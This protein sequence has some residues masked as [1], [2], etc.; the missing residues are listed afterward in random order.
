MDYQKTL[1]FLY[2]SLPQ[3]QRIGGAAYKAGLQTTEL[4]DQALGSPHQAYKT[5]H[6]AGTN[7]KGSTSQMIYEALRADGHRVGLY[8][9]PH[10]VDFRERIVVDNQMITHAGVVSFVAENRELIDRLCPSFFELTV[11]MALWWFREQKVDWAVVE[12]G[13]GG[14]LDSTN[15]ITPELSVITNISKDHTQFLGTT[16]QAI[17]AE[18]AGIIKPLVPV[19]VGEDSGDEVAAV[20]RR[21]AAEN[22]SPITF[23]DTLPP[24]PHRVGMAGHYQAR[25]AQTAYVAMLELGISPISIWRAIETAVVSGRWQQLSETPLTICDT[26]HNPAGLRFVTRQLSDLV[27]QNPSGRLYF[28]IGV[29]SD[30]DLTSIIPLLPVGAHYLV[31]QPS[32]PRAMPAVELHTALVA[33]GLSAELCTTV[34]A[35]VQRA[36]TIATPTD[37][38]FIG[39]STFTVADALPLFQIPR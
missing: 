24:Q 36:Q 8:T 30:K 6:I 23:A 13:M 5:V 21:K 27:Q 31:A 11:A 2:N 22:R 25:N 37:I 20:F 10:L 9:S 33:A 7:G 39:G 12:V 3:F 38:I 28:V 15:I 18:K 1:E 17:A 26:A 29:V 35:A 32:V 34:Q 16:L 4:L 14:R 19:V